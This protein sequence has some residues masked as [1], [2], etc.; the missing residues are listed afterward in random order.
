ML[1]NNVQQQQS[2]ECS[3]NFADALYPHFYMVAFSYK[4]AESVEQ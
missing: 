1:V 2:T 4:C 3:S